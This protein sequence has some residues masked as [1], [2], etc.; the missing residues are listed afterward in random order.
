MG[1]RIGGVPLLLRGARDLAQAGRRERRGGRS[2]APTPCLRQKIII[3]KIIRRVVIV[4]PP[5]AD[6]LVRLLRPTP[7]YSSGSSYSSSSGGTERPWRPRRP[8]PLHLRPRSRPA[9]RLHHH[10]GERLRPEMDHIRHTFRAMGTTVTMLAPWVSAGDHDRALPARSRQCFAPGGGAVLPV[11]RHERAHTGEPRRRDLDAGVGRGSRS[12]S[13]SRL[14]QADRTERVVRPH[15][16]RGG[17][18]RRL[19]PGLR[20]GPGGCPR[21]PASRPGVRSLGGGR[22]DARGRSGCPLGIGLDLGGIAKGF[23]SD[24][25]AEAA[26]AGGLPW[27]LVSAGGDLRLFGDAPPIEVGI[28]EPFDPQT[29]SARVTL[30]R[31]SARDILGGRAS[32]GRRAPSCDRSTHG[33]LLQDRRPPGNRVGTYLCRGRSAGH[34]GAV[35]RLAEAAARPTPAPSRRWRATW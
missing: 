15:R 4:D 3:R 35:E 31:G 20:R 25:A 9:A 17:D 26:V 23:T 10:E 18:R 21:R 2:R 7:T 1:E 24:L 14:S 8:R 19:R 11:P 12:W 30:T 27:A 22:D 32:V 34:L 33:G 13:A 6:L 5:V 29:S 28:E 16:A